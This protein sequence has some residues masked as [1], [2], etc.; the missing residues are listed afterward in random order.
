MARAADGV[1]VSFAHYWRRWLADKQP[2]LTVGALE[3][4]EVHGR[5]RLLPH[6]GHLAIG[7]IH[8]RLAH[9]HVAG[10]ASSGGRS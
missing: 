8:E 1:D 5:K 6:L 9:A 2:D 10:R 3:D 7:E 4:L